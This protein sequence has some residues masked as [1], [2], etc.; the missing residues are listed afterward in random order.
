MKSGCDTTRGI[1]KLLLIN[2]KVKAENEFTT[3]MSHPTILERKGGNATTSTL[4][5]AQDYPI[6][7]TITSGSVKPA[8]TYYHYIHR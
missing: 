4:T 3:T 8:L 1:N 7:L 5:N 2:I 6:S